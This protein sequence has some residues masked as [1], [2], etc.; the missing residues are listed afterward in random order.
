MS[1]LT[2]TNHQILNI[3]EH[4]YEGDEDMLYLL[5]RLKE[6]ANDSRVRHYM[7]VEDEYFSAIEHRDAEILMRDKQIAEQNTQIAEQ[8]NQLAEQ[9]TQI[10]E[11]KNQL[12]EQRAKLTALVRLML[13]QGTPSSIIASTLGISEEEIDTYK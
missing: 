7:N 4:Q 6:A 12:E 2:N 1:K 11:Q 10:A 13:S 8:K 3:D 5:R 9:N